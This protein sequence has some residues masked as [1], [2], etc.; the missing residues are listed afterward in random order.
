MNVCF[1]ILGA[2]FL[3]RSVISAVSA[4]SMHCIWYTQLHVYPTH[5]IGM[6]NTMKQL[7]CLRVVLSILLLQSC[8]GR[9]LGR[10][11]KRVV[12]EK[13]IEYVYEYPAGDPSKILFLAHGC[14]HS[15]LDFWP[16]S[17]ECPTCIGLPEERRIVTMALQR[18]YLVVAVSSAG[19]DHGGR[20]DTRVDSKRVMRVIGLL[21]KEQRALR[22]LPVFAL[23][24]SSGGVIVAAMATRLHDLAGVCIQVMAPDISFEMN[25]QLYPPSQ[26][27]YMEKDTKTQIGVN[28][29]VKALQKSGAMVQK[30][31]A[32]QI[33][34]TKTFFSDRIVDLSPALSALLY[35]A[36]LD[37]SLLTPSG[38]LRADPRHSNWRA[39]LEQLRPQLLPDTLQADRS[40]IAEELNVAYSMHEI[41]AEKMDETLAFFDKAHDIF[42]SRAH[43]HEHRT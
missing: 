18:D 32:K 39:A 4:C 21:K 33:S 8:A 27:I 16:D 6:A 40:P 36:L 43:D 11:G 23:G 28:A 19:Q 14:G 30:I 13:G 29:T 3:T 1:A 5:R 41:T 20:W 35:D 37:S 7:C 34:L 12:T 17:P 25:R 42:R 31:L 22:G 24:V 38:Y 26:W 2:F 10:H 9:D 15:A